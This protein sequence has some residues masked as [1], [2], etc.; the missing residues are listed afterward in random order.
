MRRLAVV[1]FSTAVTS[2][3]VGRLNADQNTAPTASFVES[4]IRSGRVV[5]TIGS[6]NGD[7]SQIFGRLG[8]VAV[9]RLGGVILIDDQ[10]RIVRAFDAEG[11]SLGPV[12]GRGGGPGEYR[13]PIAVAVDSQNQVHVLEPRP[14]RISVLKRVGERHIFVRSISTG[15]FATNLCIMGGDYYLSTP[16]DSLVVRRIDSNGNHVA[17]FGP[18]VPARVHPGISQGMAGGVRSSSNQALIHCDSKTRTIVLVHRSTPD[19]RAF[20]ADG[21]LLWERRLAD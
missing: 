9:D 10:Q 8:H 15:A 7:S 16:G 19:V 4:A 3:D 14:Q 1:V 21:Q 17:S 6:L 5:V 2:G 13:S 18:A 20:K 11:K 12:G